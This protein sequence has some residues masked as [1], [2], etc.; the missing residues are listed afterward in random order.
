MDDVGKFCDSPNAKEHRETARL[1]EE[2]GWTLTRVVVWSGRYY[3]FFNKP[4]ES[5]D[6]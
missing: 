1:A 6:E 4:R 5:P 3:A 2:R